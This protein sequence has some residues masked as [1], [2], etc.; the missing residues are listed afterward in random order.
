VPGY[1]TTSYPDLHLAVV[2]GVA[3]ALVTSQGKQ[4][5]LTILKRGLGPIVRPQQFS[6]QAD[7]QGPINTNEVQPLPT[8]ARPQALGSHP[9]GLRQPAAIHADI[10][11][12]K[13]HPAA[14][15]PGA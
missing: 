6:V 4:G 15:G 2:A 1:F 9:C 5:P 12:S 14:P 11:M 3:A 10:A 7:S 13:G 8:A